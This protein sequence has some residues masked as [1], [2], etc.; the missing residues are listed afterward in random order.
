MEGRAALPLRCCACVL[1]RDN[2]PPLTAAA[3]RHFPQRV[4]HKSEVLGL[5]WN[6]AQRNLLASCGADHTVRLWDMAEGK[7]LRTYTHH[8]DKVC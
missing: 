8:S 4:G 7:C 6:A 3:A 2:S 1:P 5:A